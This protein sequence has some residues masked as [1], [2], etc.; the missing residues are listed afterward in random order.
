MRANDLRLGNYVHNIGRKL[1]RVLSI[2][3]DNIY[4]KGVYSDE[5][6]KIRSLSC[7]YRISLTQDWLVKFGFEF[8]KPKSG[9]QGVFSNGK[10]NLT[11]SNSGNIYYKNISLLY[12][13]QLQNLYYALQEEELKIKLNK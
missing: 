4:G 10:I 8:L 6:S 2:D 5:Y 13:N 7:T 12:V 9:T 3:E 1:I 11:L